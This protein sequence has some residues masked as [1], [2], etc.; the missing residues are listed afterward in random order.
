[1]KKTTKKTGFTLLEILLVVALIA[2]LAGLILV[3]I[4][5][6]QRIREANDTQR[7]ADTTTLVNAIYQY[8]L[9]NSGALPDGNGGEAITSARK[10]IGESSLA[11]SGSSLCPETSTDTDCIDFTDSLISDGY[12]SEHPI[13]PGGVSSTEYNEDNTGYYV[14]T[15]GNGIVN[16][17]SCEPDIDGNEIYSSR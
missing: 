5:P 8:A 16:V 14:Y 17:G 11:C 15:D 6:A 12:I 3:A 10:I 7:Q 9:D 4:R 2:I 13:N 1:M